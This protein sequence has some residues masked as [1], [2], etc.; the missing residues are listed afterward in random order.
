MVGVDIRDLSDFLLLI[1]VLVWLFYPRYLAFF[2][3]MQINYFWVRNGFVAVRFAFDI[4]N[5]VYT[6]GVLCVRTHDTLRSSS[7]HRVDWR[8]GG[9]SAERVISTPLTV[10]VLSRPGG[11]G[12]GLVRDLNSPEFVISS[13]YFPQ[14]CNRPY[15]TSDLQPIDQIHEIQV[16]VMLSYNIRLVYKTDGQNNVCRVRFSITKLSHLFE[17]LT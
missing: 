16:Q 7:G 15:G 6:M 14:T 5:G 4:P 1:I 2:I 9:L 17:S 8:Q 13:Y 11:L 12:R 3:L 10:K